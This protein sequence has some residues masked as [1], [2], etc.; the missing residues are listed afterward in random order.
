MNFGEN[1]FGGQKLTNSMILKL[2]TIITLKNCNFCIELC[3]YGMIDIL[4]YRGNLKFIID[5]EDLG[6]TS[7]II[8]K[9]HKLSFPKRGSDLRW[10]PNVIVD[11]DE[12]SGWFIW[13]WVKGYSMLSS[14]NTHI[15]R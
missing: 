11:K 2:T 4:E 13:L 9:G 5:M 12:Q 10:T 7:M 8:N 3:F 14:L 1:P 15:T 6:K